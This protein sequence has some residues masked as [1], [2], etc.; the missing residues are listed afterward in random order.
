MRHREG[1]AGGDP[2]I[3][4][5]PTTKIFVWGCGASAEVYVV[6]DTDQSFRIESH[7]IGQAPLLNQVVRDII[8]VSKMPAPLG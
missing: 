5:E 7:A 1:C 3:E 4:Y 8:G 2:I 6:R